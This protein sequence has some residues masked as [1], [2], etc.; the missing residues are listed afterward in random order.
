MA[1]DSEG[2]TI[3][4]KVQLNADGFIESA[5]GAIV[6]PYIDGH[7]DMWLFPSD[8]E[9]DAN[10]TSNA[11]RV[12]DNLD[13]SRDGSGNVF[14]S[15]EETQTLSAGQTTVTL[16]YS[17][18]LN[19]KFY[20]ASEGVD[21][22]RLIVDVDYT[23]TSSGV[24][25]IIELINSFPDDSV[26]TID[27]V[28]LVSSGLVDDLSQAYEFPTV[29]A[30]KAFSLEFPIGKVVNLLDRG[31]SFTVIDGVG[32]SNDM[33]II[34][35]GLVSQSITYIITGVIEVDA[36]G[37]DSETDGYQAIQ[38]AIDIGEGKIIQFSSSD[39]IINTGSLNLKTKRVYRG[40]GMGG[41]ATRIKAGPDLSS[42]TKPTITP[43]TYSPVLDYVPI[44]YNSDAIQNWAIQDLLIDGNGEDV[45]GLVLHENYYGDF[46]NVRITGCKQEA[47]IN[48]RGQLVKHTSFSCYYN[49]KGAVS[50]NNT[51]FNFYSCGFEGNGGTWSYQQRQP[52]SAFN[53]GSIDLSGLWFET[54]ATLTSKPTKGHLLVSGRGVAASPMFMKWESPLAGVR[55]V[56][57]AA[58]NDEPLTLNGIDMATA[59]CVGG[60]I[61]NCNQTVSLTNSFNGDACYLSGWI[62]AALISDNGSDNGY[63]PYGSGVDSINNSVNK[64][65]VRVGDSGSGMPLGVNDVYFSVDGDVIT[66]FRAA[67]NNM[68]RVANN[69]EFNAALRMIIGSTDGID[70]DD[71]NGKLWIRDLPTSNPGGTDRLWNDSGTIKIT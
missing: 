25:N 62:D 23:V 39:Y 41:G 30:Y 20:I 63:Q 8:A 37:G 60:D 55:G 16:A 58:D 53:K 51:A 6:T 13:A 26:L 24:I 35:S 68:Q 33:D 1:L 47:Y 22:G 32:T 70:L 66:L 28:V 42:I 34:S 3:V 65:E 17:N 54:G 9:A 59:K 5:G 12:A 64:F 18:A 50:F 19:G 61:D 71:S 15:V 67:G 10:D 36:L 46:N 48:V 45:F 4:I 44:C 57:F 38:R 7:Y 69:L 11:V 40:T 43:S 49:E 31:A 21:R 2:A 14:I 52:V 29:S 56:Q 27:S